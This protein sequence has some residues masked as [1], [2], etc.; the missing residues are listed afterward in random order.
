MKSNILGA[1]LE[2]PEEEVK[3]DETIAREKAEL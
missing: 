3:K 1:F 2:K